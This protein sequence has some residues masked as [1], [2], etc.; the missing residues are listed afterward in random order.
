MKHDELV[1]TSAI[2]GSFFLSGHYEALTGPEEGA[3]IIPNLNPT[4]LPFVIGISG[5]IA[6]G[7]TTAAR[8]IERRGFSYTRISRV[9]D[10]VIIM[11]G[12]VPDRMLRQE[13][14]W[15]LHVEKGQEW[16]CERAIDLVKGAKRIVVDG[17]RFPED[18]IYFFERFGG[19]FVHIHIE[20]AKEIRAHRLSKANESDLSA[21]EARPT[22]QEIEALRAMGRVIAK[23]EATLELLERKLELVISEAEL[24]EG[25]TCQSRS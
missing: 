24:K 22:E 18:H 13:V 5:H 9:I 25:S 8:L 17:L 20:A 4:P 2:V 10:D 11:N 19:R 7:K 6:A 16:L 15:R 21:L 23:V 12:G 14:G 3:L 1:T